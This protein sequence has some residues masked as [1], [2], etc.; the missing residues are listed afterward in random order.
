VSLWS[1]LE[2]IPAVTPKTRAEA[3]GILDK[4]L[5]GA[6]V[7]ESMQRMAAGATRRRIDTVSQMSKYGPYASGYQFGDTGGSDSAAAA[8]RGFHRRINPMNAKAARRAVRRLVSSMRLLQ[9]IER[10][11]PRR[12]AAHH[13]THFPHHRRRHFR[14]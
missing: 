11:L 10:L 13:T 3:A 4:L 12:K 9:S 6:G 2:S 8:R 7:A 1:W 5:P 14:R